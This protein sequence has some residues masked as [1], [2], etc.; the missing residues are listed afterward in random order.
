MRQSGILAAAGIFALK[1][2]IN[3]LADDHANARKIAQGKIL[4]TFFL[5]A[6]LFSHLNFSNWH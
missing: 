6:N 3:R 1:N 2:H 5:N 4:A